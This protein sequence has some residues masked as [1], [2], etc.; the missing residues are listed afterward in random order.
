MIS[1]HQISELH[2]NGRQNDFWLTPSVS[3][4]FRGNRKCRK[5]YVG[6][7]QQQPWD[8]SDH[9]SG[10]RRD[11]RGAQHQLQ[12]GRFKQQ[13]SPYRVRFLR[14]KTTICCFVALNSFFFCSRFSEVR[15]PIPQKQDILVE[16]EPLFGG[17]ALCRF[18]LDQLWTHWYFFSSNKWNSFFF[19][20]AVPK[21]RRPARSIFDGFRDFQTETSTS[22]GKSVLAS[23]SPGTVLRL[24]TV[25]VLFVVRQEQEL[26][27]G[28]VDKKLS[29]L[30]DLFR[31]PIELMHKGSF[32][33][34]R[35]LSRG[36]LRSPFWFCLY[37]LSS[38][39]DIGEK[40]GLL[41]IQDPA[42]SLSR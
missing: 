26:R 22:P 23:F 29:T 2:E 3:D 28:T 19:A 13:S 10:W 36:I 9:V 1:E 37:E 4:I 20:S 33:T 17:I 30:A 5:T 35:S 6:S 40:S 11:C 25:N 16:P 15:A 21:R 42:F 32:E 7:L 18:S 41:R 38:D 8:G 31:P 27:N 34:V 12:F 14:L 24:T 39:L